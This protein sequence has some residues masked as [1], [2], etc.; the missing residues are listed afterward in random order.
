[1]DFKRLGGGYVIRDIFE[2][3][4]VIFEVYIEDRL[5][6]RQSM[7]APKE[8]LMVNFVQTAKQIGN[9]NK[10]M[11]IRM[12]RPNTIYD[13]FEKKFKELNN[14]IEFMN[15]AWLAWDERQKGSD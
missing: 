14:E 10:P 3:E 6:Q 1:M 2:M 8:I 5:I 12:T 4:E 11:R 9:D 7:Q 15:N 13:N